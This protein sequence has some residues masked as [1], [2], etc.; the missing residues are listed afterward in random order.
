VGKKN[1]FCG[2]T[3]SRELNFLIETYWAHGQLIRRGKGAVMNVG[4]EEAG[5]SEWEE[6]GLS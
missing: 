2:T 6:Q 4:G 3:P 5:G 1:T